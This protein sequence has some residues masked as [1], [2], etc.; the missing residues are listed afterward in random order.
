MTK[1]NIEDIAPT[2]KAV[3]VQNISPQ[4][5]E[6]AVKDFFS[7]C[8]KVQKFEL[9]KG[10]E[11]QEAFVLF[12]KESAANTARLLTNAVI[13]DRSIVVNPFFQNTVNEGDPLIESVAND[14]EEE[15][16]QLN[17]HKPFSR[18]VAELLANGYTITEPVVKKGLE[19]ENRYEVRKTLS[20]YFFLAQAR[21][22]EMGEK[23]KVAQMLRDID[24]KFGL[25]SK[26]NAA[27]AMATGLGESVLNTSAGQKVKSTVE[28]VSTTAMAVATETLQ[29][30]DEKHRAQQ[31][32]VH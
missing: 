24:A 13:M 9:V 8:G 29:I 21:A 16:S 19:I 6:K 23:Y 26:G 12:D 14:K 28:K 20:S 18:V 11:S 25:L 32:E 10:K 31:A 22:Y 4:A 27:L 5:T 2:S 17:G 1:F 15:K 7:F 30:V 3:L